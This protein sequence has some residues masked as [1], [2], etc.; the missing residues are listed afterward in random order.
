MTT[1]Q[2]IAAAR[3]RRS[4]GFTLVEMMISTVVLAILLESLMHGVLFMTESTTQGTRHNR[5]VSQM[6]MT[7]DKMRAE[8]NLTSCDFDPATGLPYLT[9]TGAADD[10]TI[11]FKRVVNYQS[12][13]VSMTPVWSTNVVYQRQ[14]T[15]LVRTQDGVTSILLH[16]VTQLN[17][18]AEP[19]GRIV[20]QI[21]M[22]APASDG[23]AAQTIFQQFVVAT[24]Y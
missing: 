1:L 24:A 4:G 19:T 12:N 20:I 18:T 17:F 3:R 6:Q 21:G 9:V 10:Q 14:G 22:V 8:L 13:G 2:R 5:L 11:T 15:D 23:V 7:M 16:G